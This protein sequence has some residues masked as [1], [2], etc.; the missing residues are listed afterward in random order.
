V[1]MTDEQV[2]ALLRA[3]TVEGFTL[4]YGARSSYYRDDA[5]L[6]AADGRAGQR[7]RDALRRAVAG[8]DPEE[9]PHG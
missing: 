9:K 1:S 5:E 6:R 4:P 2:D 3:L 7:N 8:A